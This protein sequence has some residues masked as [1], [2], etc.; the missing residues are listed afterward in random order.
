MPDCSTSTESGARLLRARERQALTG[1]F[2]VRL[3]L[4]LRL[5][6][7]L[8]ASLGFGN[9]PQRYRARFSEPGVICR[10]GQARRSSIIACW[11][12]W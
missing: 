12:A 3:A 8:P 1:G 10:L 4:I 5:L 7:T 6:K 9:D 11:I 2:R